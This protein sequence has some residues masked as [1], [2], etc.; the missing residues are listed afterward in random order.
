[1]SIKK[2]LKNNQGISL[3]EVI[4]VLVII[5]IG[6]LP[7]AAVQSG[8]SRD[9]VKS[10]QRTRALNIAQNQMEQTR[11]V[12]FNMAA[13]DSGM[14]DSYGWATTVT[15]EG[16]GLNRVSVTV[17]WQEG[18]APRSLTLDNFLSSR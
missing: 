5:A 18:S 1:M 9:V 4:V 10:G 2:L 13:S 6:V 7:I 11:N 16:V 17:T 15:S 14:V 3:I 12:G 8:S